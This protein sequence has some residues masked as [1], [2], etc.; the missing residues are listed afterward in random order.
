MNG[1][2][3]E[4]PSP[5]ERS[6]AIGI[7]AG[8]YGITDINASDGEEEDTPLIRAAY[9][10]GELELLRLLILAGADVNKDNKYEETPLM[11]ACIASNEEGVKLLIAAGANVDC[12]DLFAKTPLMH[13]AGQDDIRLAEILL[14]AGASVNKLDV[15]EATA[16]NYACSIDDDNPMVRL[17]RSYGGKSEQELHPLKHAVWGGRMD[18]VERLL[19]EPEKLSRVDF[20]KALANPFHNAAD[21]EILRRLLPHLAGDNWGMARAFLLD[22]AVREGRVDSVRVLLE[23]GVDPNGDDAKNDDCKEYE[24]LYPRPCYPLISAV[25]GGCF[26]VMRTECLRLLLQYGGNLDL[27]DEKGVSAREWARREGKEKQLEQLVSSV[28]AATLKQLDGKEIADQLRH[29]GITDANAADEDGVIPLVTACRRGDVR[30]V[31]LLL[32]AGADV[33][34]A[35]S[36]D[37][38]TALHAAA[39]EGHAE[40]CRLLLEHGANPNARNFVGMT[41]LYVAAGEWAADCCEVLLE[42]GADVNAKDDDGETALD[43]ATEN[44][45]SAC[46][47]VLLAHGAKAP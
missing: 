3:P 47:R 41:P 13:V 29:V 39:C 31:L 38:Y 14:K 28:I 26:G 43:L 17:L 12:S 5:E 45:D 7:L 8:K 34:A 46:C 25:C 37:S 30:L 10:E 32:S 20:E 9:H 4:T 36:F 42:H 18:E 22:H 1:Q 24:R 44:G 40:C 15:Y 19:S 2:L 11:T 6:A 21:A 23:E 33:N 16:L 27:P 35:C